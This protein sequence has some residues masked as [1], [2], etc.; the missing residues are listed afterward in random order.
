M[1]RR[2]FQASLASLAAGCLRAG[3]GID[4]DDLVAASAAAA[5]GGIFLPPEATRADRS[6][7]RGARLPLVKFPRN[8][9]L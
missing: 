2:A 3:D 6:L 1:N 4:Q 9:A 8:P 7:H 5:L